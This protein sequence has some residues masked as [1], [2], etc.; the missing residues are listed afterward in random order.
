ML[1]VSVAN[2]PEDFNAAGVLCGALGDWDAATHQAN[3]IAPEI[4]TGLFHSQTPASLADRFSGPHSA[5]L[6]ARW[7]GAPAG[8]IAFEP[9]DETA[10]EIHKFYVDPAFRRKGI[11]GRL[12][13]DLLAVLNARGKPRTLLQTSLYM[14]DAIATY[15]AF[16]FGL[17]APFRPVPDILRPTEIFMSRPA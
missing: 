1:S 9:F 2:S 8:C 17:C 10:D 11:G 4:V 15:R 14:S 7:D 16:G 3:G 5:M 6:L 13:Q 12:M